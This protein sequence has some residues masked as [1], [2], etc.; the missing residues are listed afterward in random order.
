MRYQEIKLEQEL[1]KLID[2]P[3]R[4]AIYPWYISDLVYEFL[5]NKFQ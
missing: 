5:G 1:G 2:V 3:I 4:E